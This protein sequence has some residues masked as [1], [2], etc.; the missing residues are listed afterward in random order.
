MRNGTA[1]N[2]ELFRY[3]KACDRVLYFFGPEV[4]EYL[5]RLRLHLIDLNLANSKMQNLHDPAYADWVEKKHDQFT[6]IADFYRA[7]PPMFAPYMKAHQ[8]VA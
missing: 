3:A 6:A 1:S 2:D 4:P 5:E 7:A 8:K